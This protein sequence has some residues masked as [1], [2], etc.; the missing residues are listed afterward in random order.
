M[1]ILGECICLGQSA[2]VYLTDLARNGCN[3]TAC[4]ELVPLDRD[5]A[6]WIGAIGPFNAKA[7][8]N[9]SGQ[10]RLEFGEPLDSRIVEHFEFS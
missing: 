1:E 4:G 7:S 5:L 3:V 10:V 6:L 2:Q 9:E 8:R